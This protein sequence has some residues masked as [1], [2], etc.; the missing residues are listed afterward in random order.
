MESDI[1]I[2]LCVC[3]CLPFDLKD[4]EF[5]LSSSNHPVCVCVCLPF[6]LKD[7]EFLLSRQAFNG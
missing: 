3:V 7:Y 5:L 6:D 4:Y 1:A 2:I